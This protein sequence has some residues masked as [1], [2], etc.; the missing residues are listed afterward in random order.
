MTLANPLSEQPDGSPMVSRATNN[1][2][3]T[4]PTLR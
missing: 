2:F 3:C 4:R 1:R